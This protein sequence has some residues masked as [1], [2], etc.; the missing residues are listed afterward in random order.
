MS[1]LAHF[2]K[3][4]KLPAQFVPIWGVVCSLP[5]AVS[6]NFINTNLRL[7]QVA[8]QLRGGSWR[9]RRLDSRQRPPNV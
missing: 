5:V 3:T 8:D 1:L 4:Q 2:A 6:P 9:A 7:I